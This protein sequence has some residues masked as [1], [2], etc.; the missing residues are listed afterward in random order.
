VSVIS[1]DNYS[2][3]EVSDERPKDKTAQNQKLLDLIRTHCGPDYHPILTLAEIADSG[4]KDS[5]R[6]AAAK[7]MMPFLEP[8]LKAIEIKGN[9]KQDFGVL[10]VSLMDGEEDDTKSEEEECE[11]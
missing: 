8:Q 9:L 6:V 11:E 4:D 7:A 10:K 3:K 2:N 1:E 5:D